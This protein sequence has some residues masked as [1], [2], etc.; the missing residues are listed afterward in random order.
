M[1]SQSEAE[2]LLREAL[3]LMAR[4]RVPP[5]PRNYYVWYEYV[6]GENQELVQEINSLIE[7]KRPFTESLNDELFLKFVANIEEKET[8]GKA[9]AKASQLVA[10]IFKVVNDIVQETHDYGGEV[11]K[12][13]SSLSEKVEHEEIKEIV[14]DIIS[15]AQAF[16]DRT[17]T[18]ST[19]ID[20]SKKEIEIL[21]RNLEKVKRE[22][23]IDFLTGI[24]NRKAFDKLMQRLPK[25]ADNSKEVFCLLMIDIDHFKKYN[26]TYGHQIGDEVLKIVAHSMEQLVKGKD[27]VARYGGEEFAVVLPETPLSGALKVAENIRQ[28]IASQELRRRDTGETC[29][30]VTVSIGVACYRPEED[31]VERLIQRADDALYLSKQGGRNKVTRESY[32]DKKTS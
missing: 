17:Q 31:S 23:E 15:G 13:V 30:T 2:R 7:Q 25:E 20:E 18:I 24:A 10:E 22:T 5:T 12:Y 8:L 32:N 4:H 11:D 19:K 28:A 21:R 14:K 26:D 27:Y 6:E 3:P 16:R 1:D 29:G 9:S